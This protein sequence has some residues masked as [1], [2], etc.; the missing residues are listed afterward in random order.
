MQQLILSTF[1]CMPFLIVV[2]KDIL[3]LNAA[4]CAENFV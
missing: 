2:D 3:G 1:L 4:I